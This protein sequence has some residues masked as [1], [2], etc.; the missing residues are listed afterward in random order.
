VTR[1]L[2][3]GETISLV[4]EDR[5]G[6]LDLASMASLVDPGHSAW[7]SAKLRFDRIDGPSSGDVQFDHLVGIFAASDTGAMFRL[8]IS[9]SVSLSSTAA[10]SR[11][12]VRAGD[13]SS[14]VASGAVQYGAEYS[15]FTADLAH[16]LDIGS[17]GAGSP[18]PWDNHSPATRIH[19]DPVQ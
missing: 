5:L 17:L 3:C 8:K 11:V 2:Q 14:C 12:Q 18:A 4:T 16:R 19:L 13:G 10:T 6:K 1:A 7:S 9:S 15:V